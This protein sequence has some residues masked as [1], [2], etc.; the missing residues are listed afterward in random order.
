M[1]FVG[2]TRG[3]KFVTWGKPKKEG[4]DS[5]VVKE[6]ENLTGKVLKVKDSDKY[7]KIL[8]VKVKGQEDP[9]VVIGTTILLQELGYTKKDQSKNTYK[10][11]L[12]K[13]EDAAFT[14]SEGDVIRITFNGMIT[15][16]KGQD[17][18]DLTVEKDM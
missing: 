4:D 11:N 13:R 16:G 9:L 7:G 17:A 18:Y 6:G 1:A 2:Q 14:I 3:G 5:F 15:T 10:D 12:T 8:E